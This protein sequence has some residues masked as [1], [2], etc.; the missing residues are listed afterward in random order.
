M[1]RFAASAIAILAGLGT[2]LA[3]DPI[4][5]MYGDWELTCDN[6]GHCVAMGVDESQSVV[7][8]VARES[9]PDGLL[10]VSLHAGLENDSVDRLSVDGRKIR[11]PSAGWRRSPNLLLSQDPAAAM[12]F[13][14]A[15]RKGRELS[16]AH[17]A[18]DAEAQVSLSGLSAALLRMDEVQGRLGTRTALLRR[19]GR[20]GSSVGAAPPPPVFQARPLQTMG[21]RDTRRLTSA[22]RRAQAHVL[23]RE[24]CDDD[25]GGA[26]DTAYVLGRDDAMVMLTC[27]QGAYQTSS[28]LF[29]APRSR[30]EHSAPLPLDTGDGS[31]TALLVSPELDPSTGIL[32][33]AA[34][35]RGIGDCGSYATWVFDGSRFLLAEAAR[36]DRCA[37]LQR[38]WW[39]VLM[40]ARI[41]AA[42]P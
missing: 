19:G 32:H 25:P 20:A 28:L 36:M 14:E 21:E 5:R 33:H 27:W 13:I 16:I 8:S 2:A 6:V 10:R 26:P 39:P 1:R 17:A 30:P 18:G 7:V 24:G 42:G 23:A 4:R 22:V 31:S 9:G 11:L 40:R 37:G 3:A 34:L 38:E 41:Q 15:V 35:G 12:A 29:K